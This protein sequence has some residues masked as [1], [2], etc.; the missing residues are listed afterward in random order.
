MPDILTE[1]TVSDADQRLLQQLES[2][3][4]DLADANRRWENYDGNNPNKH[5]TA[6]SDAQASVHQLELVCKERGLLPLSEAEKLWKRL[7]AAYPDS[8]SR[9]IVEFEGAHYQRKYSPVSRSLSGKS[10]KDWRKSWV[11]LAD[12]SDAV[13]AFC[14]PKPTEDEIARNRALVAK[15]PFAEPKGGMTLQLK[16]GTP[17]VEA[18]TKPE[19]IEFRKGNAV[20]RAHLV[21]TV[22]ASGEAVAT[23]LSV[24]AT[25]SSPRDPSKRPDLWVGD[26]ETG[27]PLYLR[28]KGAGFKGLFVGP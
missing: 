11:L 5:R 7:D 17:A 10:V 6:V 16:V 25:K 12:D 26:D 28:R 8:P 21:A 23:L 4:K 2:A 18:D 9:L 24:V 13:K 15:W 22:W 14:A 19:V 3:R 20:T 27:K 1:S